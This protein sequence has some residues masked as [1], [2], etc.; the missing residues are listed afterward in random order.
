MYPPLRSLDNGSHECYSGNGPSGRCTSEVDPN[1]AAHSWQLPAA[2][3]LAP[4]LGF[5]QGV[6]FGAYLGFRV[7]LGLRV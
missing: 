1:N 5:T 6:G 2:H 7:Y 4:G 3:P